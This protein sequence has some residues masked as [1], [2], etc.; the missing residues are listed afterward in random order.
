[1]SHRLEQMS[2]RSLRN[3]DLSVVR[4]ARSA[5]QVIA[6]VKGQIAPGGIGLAATKQLKNNVGTRK[7]G[8][9]GHYYRCKGG[10]RATEYK[11][12]P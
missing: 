7:S 6:M 5:T 9:N 10:N 2:K 1:M 11:T 3:P 12:L 4:G 8:K